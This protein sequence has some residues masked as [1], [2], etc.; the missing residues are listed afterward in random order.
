MTFI[1][2]CMSHS[3]TPLYNHNRNGREANGA[4][5]TISL[6]Q[7]K[8]WTRGSVWISLCILERR[9]YLVNTLSKTSKQFT[10]G[11]LIIIV[12]MSGFLIYQ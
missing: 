10:Q 4:P 5:Q 8:D 11:R 6:S 7:P 1:L 9:I 2:V 12:L 3:P